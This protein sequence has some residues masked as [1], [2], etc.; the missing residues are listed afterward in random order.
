MTQPDN[1]AAARTVLASLGI[2]LEDLLQQPGRTDVPTVRAFAETV[3]ANASEGMLA[4]YELHWKRAVELHGDQP[5]TDVRTSALRDVVT[6]A[7]TNAV[8]RANS[9]QGQGAEENAVAALRH[10]FRL[11]VEDGYRSDNPAD[12]LRKPRRPE[13]RRRPL[14]GE[15]LADLWRISVTTGNDPHLDGL[16]HRFHLET[17][18]RRGGALALRRRDLNTSQQTLLLREKN[19]TEHWQPVSRSLLLALLAHA[20]ARG[21]TAPG[22]QV[23]RYKPRSGHETGRPL[24]YRRYDTLHERWRR[25]LE[26]AGKEQVSVHWLRH[27]AIA[28]VERVAGLGVAR[29]FA[30]HR[31]ESAATTLTYLRAVDADV[32]AVVAMLTGE[33][34]PLAPHAL[35]NS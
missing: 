1:L 4:A 31:D 30:R 10:F 2:T 28:T 5:V 17:G 15:E 35:D 22:D 19:K 13:S 26:W 33:P 14:N 12:N 32:A 27:T 23:F 7:V 8:K 24:T 16:L 9:R 20:D 21:A 25:H 6:A 29:R 34:H 11:V 3:L 18:A